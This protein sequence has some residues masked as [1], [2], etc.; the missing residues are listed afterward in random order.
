MNPP[1]S[2]PPRVDDGDSDTGASVP[3]PPDDPLDRLASE[4][5]DSDRAA[6]LERE[7]QLVRALT[8]GFVPEALP[9]MAGHDLGIVYR[10][11]DEEAAGGDLYGAWE[12]P[13]R[14]AAILIGD[15]T[16][17]GLETAATSA[18]VRFFVEALSWDEDDPARVLARADEILLRR[19]PPDTFATA[20][21]GVLDGEGVEFANAGHLPPLLIRA[22]GGVAELEG[23]GVPLGIGEAGGWT[24]RRVA[25]EPGDLLLAYTDGLLEARRGGELFGAARMR[26]LVA[27]AAADDEDLDTLAEHVHEAVH[28]WAG[29]LDDDAVVLALRRTRA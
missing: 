21:L 17:K 18:M 3:V 6:A 28:G 10:P 19:L 25:L 26:E 12:L 8:R 15:V 4:L 14:R 7:H 29:G 13:G 2:T 20:F 23:G 27:G 24:S 16:G 1:D 11:A 22:A 9:A 5:S